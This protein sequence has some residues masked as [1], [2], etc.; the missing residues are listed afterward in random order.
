MKLKRWVLACLL[1]MG[2]MA[3]GWDPIPPETW[4][5]KPQSTSSSSGAIYLLDWS[6]Y[7]VRDTEHRM[8]ILVMTEA[9]KAA[10]QL[11]PFSSFLS[12][13][14]GRTVYP[15]GRVL[16]F[17]KAQDFSNLT[18]KRGFGDVS[19]KVVVPPGLTDHCVVDLHWIENGTVLW[20]THFQR[21][22][23]RA[24]P[25]RELVIQFTS[26]SP[27]GSVWLKPSNMAMESSKDGDYLVYRFKD[28]PALEDEPY[29]REAWRF[30]P[31]LVCFYQPRALFDALDGP[32]AAYWDLAAKKIL[33]PSFEDYLKL[34]K[35]YWALKEELCSGLPQD[36]LEAAKSILDRLRGKV[37]NID[38]ISEAEKKAR[39]ASD[40]KARIN[41]NDLDE[42]SDRRWTNSSGVFNLAFRL[43]MDA[44]L[45][46]KLILAADRDNREFLFDLKDYHQVDRWLIAVAGPDGKS[47]LI[48]QPNSRLLPLGIIDSAFQG[49]KALM[50]DSQ[51][52]SA[53]PFQIPF[54]SPELSRKT[55]NL[56]VDP[57]EDGTRFKIHQSS[58][59]IEGWI[60]RTGFFSLTREEANRRLKEKLQGSTSIT[61]EKVDIPGWD[62]PMGTST[63]EAEGRSEL[64]GGRRRTLDPFPTLVCPMWV[65][66]SWPQSRIDPV[67]M[68]YPSFFEATSRIHVPEG[69]KADLPEATERDNYFGKVTWKAE[70]LQESGATTILVSYTVR[71]STIL[72]GAGRELDLR[73]LLSWVSEAW[74]RRITLEKSR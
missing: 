70:A 74:N 73:E 36:P 64:D 25:I 6:R 24:Y 63:W 44:N 12:E 59:G 41:A 16:E 34:G 68:Y 51:D 4:S 43:L 38:T 50:V 40:A 42:A 48:S 9:G 2:L 45:H 5:I 20:G 54:Q 53:H 37:L 21:W 13:V 26:Q 7:G 55:F 10:V 69:W 28:L 67:V 66:T 52:W 57:E 27:M 46:P 49:T 56:E 17:G 11:D 15:D 62:Q 19:L 60:E 8:R 31:K 35:H 1:P 47:M 14:E 29:S 33:K 61:I 22:V 23:Q 3:S 32:A 58:D 71:V 65:P 18:V 39:R 72:G 30:H